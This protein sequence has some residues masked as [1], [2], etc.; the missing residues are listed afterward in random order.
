MSQD[1]LE[2]LDQ[3]GMVARWRPVHLGQV[4]VLNAL[5]KKAKHV[6]IGIG[7]SN[8][9]D[10]RSPFT[11]DET[12]DMLALALTNYSNYEII[13]VPDLFDGPRWR[14][15][16]L[17]LFGD[18]DLFVTDNP[19]VAGLMKEDYQVIKP[20][21]LV[22]MEDRVRVSGTMVRMA[23]A[24][25]EDWQELVPSDIAKYIL[26]QKLDERFRNEFGL[27]TLAMENI[28]QERSN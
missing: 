24:R 6:K 15:M 5:C 3:I 16:V 2:I 28:I 13:P 23:M 1:K 17:K 9:Y 14:E 27:K 22:P 26:D 25:G 11:L 20:V 10:Y 12:K 18:L 19:Y 21:T 4:A 8:I 7:S